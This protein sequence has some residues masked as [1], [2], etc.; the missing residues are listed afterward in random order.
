MGRPTRNK[1]LCDKMC[2]E[3]GRW[4]RVAG[5][6][7]AIIDNSCSDA[8]ILERAVPGRAPSSFA[9]Q[10]LYP[11]RS[12][13]KRFPLSQRGI[14]RWLGKPASRGA[15]CRLAFRSLL[16]MPRV[17]RRSRRGRPAPQSTRGGAAKRRSFLVLHRVPS[18]LLARIAHGAHGR[19]IKSLAARSTS[20][21]AR[22]GRRCLR[23]CSASANLSI[24]SWKSK[25]QTLCV[26]FYP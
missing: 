10:R 11:T 5:Y 6:D 15:K 23:R 13:A 21:K 14:P 22:R 9:R 19:E 3:L 26:G 4:L 1:F 18:G 7:T 12:G 24:L 17:Q 25:D 16:Q 20:P 2:A 8:A